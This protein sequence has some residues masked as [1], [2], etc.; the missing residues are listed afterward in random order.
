MQTISGGAA[1]DLD[2]RTTEWLAGDP[3]GNNVVATI[4]DGARD[5]SRPFRYVVVYGGD[6]EIAGIGVCTP[7]R[8][9]ALTPMSTRAA[10]TLAERVVSD[11]VPVS[12]VGG[13]VEAVEAFAARWAGLT[14]GTEAGRSGLFVYGL[15]AVASPPPVPGV[16]RPARPA[17]REL[18]LGWTRA[19]LGDIHLGRQDD[20]ESLLGS[21]LDAGRLFLWDVD[22]QVVAMTGTS[23]RVGGVTRVSLVYTPPE[24]RRNGFAAALVAA[25][26][27]GELAAG[28]DAC[29]LFTEVANPTSN[30]VYTRIGYAPLGENLEITFDQ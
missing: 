13:P 22:G 27:S 26:S 18:L 4:V 5:G 21:R 17:D 20:P 29:M 15:E 9:V 6:A 14:G 23:P 11:E 24:F 3:V 7:P 30:G 2:E 25:V 19:F 8:P 28:A 16:L 12:G 10:E 1:A